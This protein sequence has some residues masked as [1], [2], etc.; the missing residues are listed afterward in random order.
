METRVIRKVADRKAQGI[1]AHRYWQSRTSTERMQAVY[2]LTYEAFASKGMDV[3][4]ERSK[5][6][7]AR[8][9]RLAG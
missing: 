1:E 3:H 7:I 6:H 4:V 5:R 2:E 9:Q 8:F